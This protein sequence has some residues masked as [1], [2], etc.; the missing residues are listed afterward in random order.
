VPALAGSAGAARKVLSPG[1]GCR[2]WREVGGCSR[3]G[4]GAEP[5]WQQRRLDCR[6]GVTGARL[7][8]RGIRLRL[9]SAERFDSSGGTGV[10]GSGAEGTV[11]WRLSG[12]T[13]SIATGGSRGAFGVEHPV[14]AERIPAGAPGATRGLSGAEPGAE[15][16]RPGG[17]WIVLR[18]GLRVS[19]VPRASAASEGVG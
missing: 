8:T 17:G 2:S 10:P 18:V 13:V 4:V 6:A 3:S 1:G 15:R 12:G 5:K 14:G 7:P 9:W 19:G 16:S 11:G